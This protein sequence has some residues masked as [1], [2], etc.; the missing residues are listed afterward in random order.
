MSRLAIPDVMDYVAAAPY[1]LTSPS[2]VW[3]VHHA[4]LSEYRVDGLGGSRQ[5]LGDNS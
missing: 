4:H 5:R 2:C 3:P 1:L